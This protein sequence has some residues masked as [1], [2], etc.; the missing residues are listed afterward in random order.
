MRS[1]GD[2]VIELHIGM[3]RHLG[4]T[5]TI[6]N[7][8]YNRCLANDWQMDVF[9][10]RYIQ[11]LLAIFDYRP[12]RYAG[13]SA[14]RDHVCRAIDFL[15]LS[16]P[17]V[18]PFLRGTHFTLIP[19]LPAKLP[20]SITLPTLR[21]PRVPNSTLFFQFDSRTIHPNKLPVTEEVMNKMVLD[22]G[23]GLGG[24]ETVPYLKDR[25]FETGNLEFIVNRLAGGRFVGIDSGLSHLAGTAKVPGDV[26]INHTLEPHA[27]ELQ[28][29][30][31]V[32]Y[33]SLVCHKLTDLLG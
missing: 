18:V 30:Y 12:L 2:F 16:G 28:A 19:L 13:A 4:D 17:A 14:D 26:Y 33:P 6:L 7:L 8:C 20:S 15:P 25:R 3:G 22:Q 9:G 21:K 29:F 31:R 5:V 23:V 11:E 32:S 10:P 1:R 24:K 27:S